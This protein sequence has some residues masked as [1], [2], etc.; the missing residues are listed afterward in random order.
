MVTVR[1]T[2]VAPEKAVFRPALSRDF[3]AGLLPESAVAKTYYEQLR[4][5]RWQRRRL[6]IMQRAD[7]ECENCGV[8]DQTLN[9]HHKLYRKNAAPWDYENHELTCLCE[10]C[11]EAEHSVRAEMAA[12][13]ARCD[14]YDMRRVI[15][16][17]KGLL[18]DRTWEDASE[19]ALRRPIKL[20]HPE[21]FFG[22]A[23]FLGILSTDPEWDQLESQPLLSGQLIDIEVSVRRRRRGKD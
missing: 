11:H 18:N 3:L 6:E 19:D 9:V 14:E 7:F 12:L 2:R 22:M 4:D 17:L 23:D 16:Y 8:K 13:L 15:G 20:S 10:G 5:P 21:E 1:A